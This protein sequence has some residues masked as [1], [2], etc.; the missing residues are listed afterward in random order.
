MFKGNENGVWKAFNYIWIGCTK[1]CNIKDVIIIHRPNDNDIIKLLDGNYNKGVQLRFLE[2]TYLR[3]AVMAHR[4]F[5]DLV[6]YPILTMDCDIILEAES[7][8]KM[9][10]ECEYLL[11]NT[12]VSAAIAVID[13][14]VFENNHSVI[15]E[16]DLVTTYK[17]TGLE[18]GKNAGYI[19]MW[20]DSIVSFIEKYYGNVRLRERFQTFFEYYV[21]LN[22]VGCM[23]IDYLWDVDTP[24]MVKLT[25][26]ILGQ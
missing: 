15:L 12:E 8:K 7:L 13:N 24:E 1:K 17:S 2:D 14:S 10:I 20:R 4:V 21:C 18:S 26:N 3:G 22:K 23:H 5:D 11:N 19:Y 16:N 6:Q 25:E 9:L